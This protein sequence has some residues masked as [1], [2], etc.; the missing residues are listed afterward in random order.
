MTYDDWKASP[1]AERDPSPAEELA[2]SFASAL[3]VL[4]NWQ[5]VFAEASEAIA[6]TGDALKRACRRHLRGDLVQDGAG[7]VQIKPTDQAVRDRLAGLREAIA[8]LIEIHAEA[9]RELRLDA[10]AE[11]YG[12][13]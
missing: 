4:R 7:I 12:G 5:E 11:T 1:P 3:E 8:E 9:E 13:R 10:E 6:T 2:D